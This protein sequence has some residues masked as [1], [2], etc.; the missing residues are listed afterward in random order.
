MSVTTEKAMVSIVSPKTGARWLFQEKSRHAIKWESTGVANVRIFL[1]LYEKEEDEKPFTSWM[2]NKSIDGVAA[3][4]RSYS[5]VL[6]EIE[7][8]SPIIAHPLYK[9]RILDADGMAPHSISG[10]FSIVKEM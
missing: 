9:I 5:V 1:E 3:I 6:A 7:H 4:S 2:V 8:R 10:F